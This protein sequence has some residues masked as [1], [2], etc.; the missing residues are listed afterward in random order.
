MNK[1]KIPTVRLSHHDSQIGNGNINFSFNREASAMIEEENIV[2]DKVNLRIRYATIDDNKTYKITRTNCGKNATT[3]VKIPNYEDV[4]GVYE[5]EDK[6]MY[7][8]LYKI[9]D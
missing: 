9:E 7:F 5:I 8:Q 2:V 1:L 4:I 6:G 3:T